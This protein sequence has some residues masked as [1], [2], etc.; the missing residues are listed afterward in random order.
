MLGGEGAGP[1][2]DEG[3]DRGAEGN[4]S[5]FLV[6]LKNHSLTH[7]RRSASEVIQTLPSPG[8]VVSWTTS[9]QRFYDLDESFSR[10]LD[11]LLDDEKYVNMLLRL[12]DNEL[13]RLVN[14]LNDVGFPPAKLI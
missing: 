3:S 11:K 7:L 2:G 4:V 6:Y 5:L 8:G 10:N 9:S 13:N 12:P 1:P 14:Y